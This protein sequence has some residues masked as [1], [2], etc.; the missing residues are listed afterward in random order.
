MGM[1]RREFV[2]TAGYGLSAYFL[3]GP[4]AQSARAIDCPDQTVLFVVFLRGGA[5]GLNL[6]IPRVDDANYMGLRPTIQ[7]DPALDVPLGT[8]GD[9]ALHPNLAPLK[10]LYDAGDMAVVHAVGGTNRYSHFEAQDAM[11]YVSPGT[12]PRGDGWMHAMLAIL[13]AS[14][15]T[16]CVTSTLRGVSLAA[17]TIPSMRGNRELAPVSIALP[18]LGSF[19]LQA[20]P[21]EIES[22]YADVTVWDQPG[23]STRTARELVAVSSGSMLGALDILQTAAATAPASEYAYVPGSLANAM[24][25]AARL[26]KQ[27]EIGLR[28]LAVD[29]GGWDHHYFENDVLPGRAGALANALASF[30]EDLGALKSRVVTLVMSEFGRTAFQNGSGGCD[31]GYGNVMFVLGGG[32]NGGRVLSRLD[33]TTPGDDP[34]LLTEYSGELA[35]GGFPGL[36]G[37]PGVSTTPQLHVQESTNTRRD[38]KATTDFREVFSECM[39]GGLGMSPTVVHSGTDLNDPTTVLGD[40]TPPTAGLGLFT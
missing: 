8:N 31:H 11:E 30:Y 27:P 37:Y 14:A 29:I 21:A 40:Y 3:G 9:F 2:R 28:G 23:V 34:G 20:D 26:V 13:G 36:G 5:D 35:N 12:T 22:L 1:T 17:A 19:Q 4:F 25:D 33:V 18:S 15:G 10:P 38:L 16:Q 24:R 7:I 6:V 39:I 32:V